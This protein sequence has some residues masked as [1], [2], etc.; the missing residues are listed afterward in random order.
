MNK[1]WFPYYRCDRDDR[2][3]RYKKVERSSRLQ[4]RSLRSLHDKK[5]CPRGP[6]TNSDVLHSG[7]FFIATIAITV[8]GEWFPYDRNDR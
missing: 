1:G 8:S 3:D 5:I 2:C 4:V 6:G 7:I